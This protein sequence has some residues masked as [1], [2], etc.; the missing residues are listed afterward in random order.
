MFSR[1]LEHVHSLNNKCFLEQSA[2]RCSHGNQ[3]FLYRQNVGSFVKQYGNCGQQ[4]MSFN[5]PTFWH[6]K[7]KEE[8]YSLLIHPTD[9]ELTTDNIHV[10]TDCV[11][12]NIWTEMI[13]QLISFLPWE[14]Q[15]IIIEF[16]FN[17]LLSVLFLYISDNKD[18]LLMFIFVF[19]NE[20]LA[21]SKNVL[22]DNYQA[23]VFAFISKWL[24]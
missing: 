19:Y 3:S 14:N 22:F 10:S 6:Y 2:R 20:I 15:C 4:I 24:I 1:T 9:S 8:K 5:W 23:G 7:K 21:E 13:W 11:S 18:K 16:N 12:K 17:V